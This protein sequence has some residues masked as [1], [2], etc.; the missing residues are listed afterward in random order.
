MCAAMRC[1]SG[2]E[3]EKHGREGCE[4]KSGTGHGGLRADE[5]KELRGVGRGSLRRWRRLHG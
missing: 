1:G 4:K 2:G 5:A 3:R